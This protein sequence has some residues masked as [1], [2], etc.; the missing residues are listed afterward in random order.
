MKYIISVL[1]AI[2]CCLHTSA[3]KHNVFAD[4]ALSL[5]YLDPGF[6]A[7]YNY[8][9]IKYIGV[10]V[11]GQGYVFHPAK[12][13]FREFTPAVFADFRFRIRPEKISQYY[14]LTDVGVDFY[15]HSN[16]TYQEGYYEYSVPKDNGI[17]LGLGIGYFLRLT[18]SGWGPYCT[19]KLI[20]NIYELD[21][22]N[23]RTREQK[24]KNVAGG[25]VIISLGFRFGD[26]DDVPKN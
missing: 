14:V 12:T 13:S 22:Y 3:Q 10:G 26:N 18:H 7:T 4:G 1:L 17:Y 16:E 5:A 11:G 8:N 21:Q 19:I 25:T 24:S 2:C 23:L 6:S 20:N 15:K 9:F